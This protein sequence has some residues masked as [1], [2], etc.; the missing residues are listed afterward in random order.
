MTYTV[1]MVGDM[2]CSILDVEKV[3]D[4]IDVIRSYNKDGEL[5]AQFYSEK[6]IGYMRG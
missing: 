1:F 3:D 5:I 2:S 6:I 4:D